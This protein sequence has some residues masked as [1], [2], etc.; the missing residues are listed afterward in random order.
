M[1]TINITVLGGGDAQVTDSAAGAKPAAGG[2]KPSA[3]PKPAANDATEG[4][5]AD[6]LPTSVNAQGE[7]LPVGP[8]GTITNKDGKVLVLKTAAFTPQGGLVGV[9]HKGVLTPVNMQPAAK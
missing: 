1:T 9:V 4:N 2:A 7:D 5:A 3:A 6:T 8:N